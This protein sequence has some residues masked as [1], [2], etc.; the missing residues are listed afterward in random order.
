MQCPLLVGGDYRDTGMHRTY[1]LALR[2]GVDPVRKLGQLFINPPPEG[3]A[4]SNRGRC[5][6][7]AE[8]GEVLV[9]DLR[10]M[11]RV[12][13]KLHCSPAAVWRKRTSMTVAA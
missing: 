9:T 3:E 12:S 6:N 8:A 5:R 7:R 13:T 2:F 1:D 10:S 11:R 4:V